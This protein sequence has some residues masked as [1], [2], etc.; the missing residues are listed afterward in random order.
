MA[1]RAD[2]VIIGGGII[3]CACAYF[4]AQDGFRVVLI[5]RAEIASG[6]AS[7][8]GG[9]VILQDKDTPEDVARALE[10]RRLYDVLADDT[11][12]VLLSTGGLILATDDAEVRRLH[13]QAQIARAGGATVE[14]L[15]SAALLDLEPALARD[16]AGA[17][18]GAEEATVDPPEVCSAL[19]AR[20]TA[21]GSRAWTNRTVTGIGITHGRVTEVQTAQERIS[22]PAVV[23]ACGAWSPQIGRMVGVEIPVTPRRGH[24]ALVEEASLVGRPMLEAG[25]L[26]IAGPDRVEDPVGIR[27]VLQPRTGRGMVVGSSRE[28]RGF[29]RTPD[30]TIAAHLWN[31]AVRY[32]PGLSGRRPSRV[33]VGLRP[34]TPRGHPLVGRAGPDGFFIATGHEGEG[35]TL[36]PVTGRMISDLIAGRIMRT[37]F[38]L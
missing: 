1:D 14:I 4:L 30:P 7:A 20:M 33:V 27:T 32:A 34:F 36:A 8:S 2:V 24:L 19:I 10:S 17:L 25:Y 22:T 21:E 12:F 28:F 23:C 37:G 16:L 15:D 9:W 6:T 18:Y 13:H 5:E 35:I 26:D 3:G 38:E 29:D 11:G 31:R